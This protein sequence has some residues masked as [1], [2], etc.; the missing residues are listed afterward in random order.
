MG[1]RGP[2]TSNNCLAAKF[3]DGTSWPIEAGHPGIGWSEPDFWDEFS[4]FYAEI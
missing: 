2:E 4:P 3:D 1:G